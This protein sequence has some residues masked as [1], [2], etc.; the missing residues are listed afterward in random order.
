MKSYVETVLDQIARLPHGNLHSIYGAV[1]KVPAPIYVTDE[2]GFV[3]HFNPWC[4][5]FAGR[6]PLAG[7]D[8]WCV[9]W[10]LYDLEGNDLPHDAC[11]M[12]TAILTKKKIRGVTAIAARPDGTRVTFMPFPTPIFDANDR[13]IGAVNMLVDVTE[14]RQPRD[15]REQAIRCE[16]LAAGVGDQQASEAL[17]LMAIQYTIRAEALSL[18]SSNQGDTQ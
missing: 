15:L 2:H 13:L 16:R 14:L 10:K 6:T 3:L 8:R 5:G 1:D 4:Y 17:Q 9:T 7:K 18:K 11:P 12:A